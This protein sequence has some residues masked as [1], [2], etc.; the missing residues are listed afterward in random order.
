MP[1]RPDRPRRLRLLGIA[2]LILGVGHVPLPR[3][4][5]HNI[6]HHDGPGEVCG[7]H[8][9][10]LRWHPDADAAVDVALL[11]WHWAPPD[12]PQ[13]SDHGS[14]ARLTAPD[15]MG[16]SPDEAPRWAPTPPPRLIDRPVAPTSPIASILAFVEPRH[17][18]ASMRAGPRTAHAF[19]ATFAPRVSRN[20]L[21]Q[22]WTC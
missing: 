11:H 15:W 20:A 18:W 7:L 16:M 6:R 19:G 3:A 22:L 14:V 2:L 12:A 10:L 17:A 4:D 13:G 1:S 21:L 5:F 8:A 9:H